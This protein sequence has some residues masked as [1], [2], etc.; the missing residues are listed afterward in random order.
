MA[1]EGC[2]AMC[3]VPHLSAQGLCKVRGC[4]NEAVSQRASCETHLD[5]HKSR[6]AAAQAA[7]DA[8]QVRMGAGLRLLA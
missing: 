5:M 2:F 3:A 6:L 1:L 7:M 8:G 4:K